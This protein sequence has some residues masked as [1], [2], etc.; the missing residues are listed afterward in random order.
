VLGI[1]DH[2]F[3]LLFE[4]GQAF[5]DDAEVL[6]SGSAQHFGD[7]QHG[8]LADDSDHRRLGLEQRLDVR[9]ALWLAAHAAGHAEGGQ[10]GVAQIEILGAAEKGRI[11]RVGAGPAAFD[12]GDAQL[13]QQ[14]GDFEL[15]FD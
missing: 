12:V 13:V 8:R 1:I 2:F 4:V 10:A 15:V 3:A 11:L 6:L 14:A 5:A 7:V 9:I